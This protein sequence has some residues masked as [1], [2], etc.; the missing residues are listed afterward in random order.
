MTVDATAERVWEVLHNTTNIRA[1]ELGHAWM[2]RIGVP[3]P[4]AGIT[5]PSPEGHVRKVTMGKAIQ[6]E[7]SGHRVASGEACSLGL[8][9]YAKSFPTP[10]P[11]R[12]RENWWSL[13]RPG[14]YRVHLDTQRGRQNQPSNSH[15]LPREHTIQLV[16]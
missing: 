7:A 3:L 14:R 4:E 9:F 1:D 5:K 10:R 2:Y 11:G 13:L 15:S 6:F 8:P 16:R 12:S